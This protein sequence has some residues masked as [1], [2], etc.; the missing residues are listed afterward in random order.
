MF[1]GGETSL[2]NTFA[3]GGILDCMNQY[4]L[5]GNEEAFL[6]ICGNNSQSYGIVEGGTIDVKITQDTNIHVF[7]EPLN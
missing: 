3:D 7:V 4:M 6:P 1:M 2:A 5:T